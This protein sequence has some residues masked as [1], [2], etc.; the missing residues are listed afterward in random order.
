VKLQDLQT[1]ALL[2]SLDRFE[3]NVARMNERA[4]FLRVYL[5]PHLKTCKS[6]DAARHVLGDLWSSASVS[7]LAETTAFFEAGILD[8]RYTAPFSPEKLLPVAPLIQQGLHFEI[9]VGDTA[10]AA[11]IGEQAQR[12][13]VPVHAL[14]E[15][16]VDGYR[17]GVSPAAPEFRQLAELLD[18][19]EYL[20]LRGLYSYGGSTY[21]LA[22]KTER[23]ALIE[24]HR[25]TLVDAAAE[26]RG[27]GHACPSLGIGSSP[28]LHDAE[29]YS[30]VDE[31]CAGVYVFQDL[32]QRGIGVATL[33]DIAVSVLATV[34]QHLP[35]S[36]R[37]YIDA[38]ALALAQDRSTAN[39]AE[40]QGY[41]LVCD[42]DTLQ[43]LGDGDV[44]VASVSQEHGLVQ[45]RDGSP[46]AA[47]TLSPGTRVRVLPNHVCM[48]ANAYPGYH[49][50]SGDRIEAWWP[51]VNG[52]SPGSPP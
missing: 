9:L 47:G 8:L 31:A 42:A 6:V 4:D 30:E 7:T 10:N 11:A 32:A 34:V 23:V 37:T 2:L 33:D 20:Q 48:T 15:V 3:R 17:G 46:I 18:T 38:G 27:Y 52:W 49:V 39:Q 16:D 41:G 40:D 51:R 22:D 24:R 19:H 36:G 14:I 12:L 1:P 29:S 5:R 25:S 21:R 44:I 50:V 43:P 26:L 28:A 35:T 45:R 13:S